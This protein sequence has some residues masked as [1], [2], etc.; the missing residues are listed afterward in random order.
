M[1]MEK[2]NVSRLRVL[3]GRE[4][5]YEGQ[6][7]QII[8]ILEDGP[9]VVLQNKDH[10]A[11]IQADQHGEAHRKVPSTITVPILNQDGEELTPAFC[12]MGLN[13]IL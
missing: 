1:Q 3:I 11:T 5:D 13:D 4:V 8:E 10:G 2:I 7:C 12:A 9:A 6:R